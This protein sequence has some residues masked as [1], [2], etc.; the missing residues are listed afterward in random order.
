M[1]CVLPSQIAERKQ[2]R[3]P[4]DSANYRAGDVR[5]L[6]LD[7]NLF[8]EIAKI[9]VPFKHYSSVVPQVFERFFRATP[10][11]TLF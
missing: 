4:F 9:H 8:P 5:P 10:S 1:I 2:L 6:E 3:R 11:K 7:T